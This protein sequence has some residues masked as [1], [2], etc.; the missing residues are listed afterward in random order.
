MNT[1]NATDSCPHDR[2]GSGEQVRPSWEIL[3]EAMT[4]ET[5]GKK[6]LERLRVGRRKSTTSQSHDVSP[7]VGA[8]ASS[9]GFSQGTEQ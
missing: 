6:L 9:A 3:A 7:Q 2:L 4:G 8:I 1:Q 5:L